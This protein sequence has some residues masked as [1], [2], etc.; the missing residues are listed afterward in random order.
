MLPAQDAA[1]EVVRPA[2]GPQAVQ[3]PA[4]VVVIPIHEAIERGLHHMVERGVG[5]A[6]DLGADLI[7]LDIDT[8]GGT[9]DAAVDIKTSLLDAYFKHGIETAS[10]VN[11]EAIS[12]GALLAISTRKIFITKNGLIGDAAPVNMMG[13]GEQEVPEKIVSY[14]RS[15]FESAAEMNGYPINVVLAM[16]DPDRPV[17]GLTREGEL[18]TLTADKALE[19]HIASGIV[20][21]LDEA[22]VAAGFTNYRTYEVAETWSEHIARFLTHPT[23]TWLLLTVGILALAIEF[24]TPGIGIPATVAVI[25]FVI[26][27]WGHTVAGLAGYESLLLFGIGVILL[28]IELFVT[29]GFGVLG[30]L[31][32]VAMF[33]ALVLMVMERVPWETARPL[34]L[35]DLLMPV[36]MVGSSFVAAF[37]GLFVLS[38]FLPRRWT[39]GRLTLSEAQ[40]KET[41]YAPLEVGTR[42]LMGET[43][44]AV[45]DLRP[46]GVAR[47]AERRLDVVTQGDH[48]PQGTRVRV[49]RIEGRRIVVRKA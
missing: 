46:A 11:P 45:S 39:F 41:G 4:L 32:I 42:G 1:T 24:Y 6:G 20:E 18:L 36:L 28:G 35:R 29:P 22:I 44:V 13:G 3:G 15:Q 40:L 17:E 14:V 26:V 37:G 27:F 10:F 9:V 16:V 34:V 5:E 12:A 7:I 2:T 48:I 30:I 33:A 21:T 23:V 31:G 49:I 19:Y 8:P 43:G 25:C 47:F 38:L